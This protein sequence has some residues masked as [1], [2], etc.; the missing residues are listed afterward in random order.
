MQF[1]SEFYLQTRRQT[2]QIAKML[3]TFILSETN[4]HVNTKGNMKGHQK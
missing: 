1:K 4:A 2:V 3:L